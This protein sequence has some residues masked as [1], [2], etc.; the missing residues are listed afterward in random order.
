MATTTIN[1][2]QIKRS[3]TTDVPTGLE[4]GELAYSFAAANTLYIGD[5]WNIGSAIPIAGGNYYYLQNVTP[6]Q[7]IPGQVLV[8][9]PLGYL[10]QLNTYVLNINGNTVDSIN[11]FSNST[12]LGLSSNTELV[13]SWTIKNYVDLNTNIQLN[14][15][16]DVGAA[17]V[18]PKT[19][20]IGVV[21]GAGISTTGAGQNIT[22][23]LENSGVVPGVY[24]APTITVDQYGRITDVDPSGMSTTLTFAGD[25]GVDTVDLFGEV[26]IF[27]GGPGVTTTASLNRVTYDVD[28]DAITNYVPSEHIDHAT[29]DIIAGNGLAGGGTL[30]GDVTLSLNVPA[31]AGLVSNT[32]G[33]FVK[34]GLGVYLDASGNV[35]IGQDVSTTSDV[36]FNDGTFTGNLFVQGA[37]TYLHSNTLE[38]IDPLIRLAA[39]NSVGDTVD[40]GFY[41]ESDLG[42]GLRFTGLFRDASDGLYKLFENGTAQ[43]TTTVN[44]PYNTATLV[45]NITGSIVNGLLQPIEVVDGGT[46]RNSLDVNGVM[47]G[48]GTNPVK[49]V[50]GAPW[51][52]FQVDS[53]GNPTWGIL[54][55]GTYP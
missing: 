6:G 12:V 46:S 39:N 2:I 51:D 7:N 45:A 43:P 40:I 44:A 17:T 18:N 15:D 13:T 24:T 37:V 36:I 1:T 5:A 27:D 16:T 34:T 4:P 8:P 25:V 26:L 22:F 23:N 33:L 32:T 29:L 48:D 28:H 35:A 21:G 11:T 53:L 14:F 50:V 20:L 19:Q 42:A 52:V 31:T 3:L 9:D 55:C 38:V 10:D 49:T 41:G 47:I 30:T 54:D